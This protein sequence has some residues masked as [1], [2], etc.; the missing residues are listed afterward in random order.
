MEKFDTLYKRTVHGKI[1][2]W[3]QEVNDECTAYRTVS[4]QTDGKKVISEWYYCEEKNVGRANATTIQ[5]QTVKEVQSNYQ[6]K[7]DRGY[8]LDIN[9]I[10]NTEALPF[11]PMLAE[12]YKTHKPKIWENIFIQAKLDGI[13]C[14]AFNDVLMSRKWK[15]LLSSPHILEALQPL[16]DR[17]GPDLILDG[18]LYAHKLRDDFEKIISLARKTKPKPQDLEE[19]AKHV[20]Y[21][22]YDVPSLQLPFSERAKFLEELKDLVSDPIVIV[23]TVKAI[24][25]DHV[26]DLFA[27]YLEEGMEGQMIRRGDA[28]YENKRTSALV[29][30]KEFDEDE[31]TVL[32]IEEGVGNRAGMA[33]KICYET[34]DGKSFKSGIRGSHEYCKQ[35]LQEKHL[36]IGNPGTVVYFGYTKYGIPRF[37]VTKIIYSTKERDV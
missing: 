10:D 14:L 33:G 20:Q 32:D 22:I 5:E 3:Y 18:E 31:F 11:Y 35:L 8:S 28:Y 6:L 21:W 36:Y 15:P 23:P 7:L 19:S 1:Q 37:P 9:E 4:G 13:R 25:E 17:F 24:D 27:Q 2:E 34:H 26:N 16:F 30:R 12:K 29:K